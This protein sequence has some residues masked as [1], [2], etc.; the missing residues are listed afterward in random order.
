MFH[1][2]QRSIL[3]LP[4]EVAAQI[5]SS[6]AIPSLTGVVLELLK[7]ALDAKATR[8]DVSVDFARG[9]CTVEDDGLGIPPLEFREEGGLGTL[10][11]TSKYH[12]DEALLGRNGTFLASLAA[13][14]LFTVASRHHEYRTHN[15]ITF[16]QSKVIERQVPAAAHNHVHS[17]HGTRV[18]VRNL[19]GNLP[20]RVKQRALVSEQRGEQDRL[21]DALKGEMARLLL[22][23]QDGVALK[24]RDSDNR[25]VINFS[26]SVSKASG[27]NHLT[28]PRS[29]PLA[30]LLTVLTQANYIAVDDW[31]SW[32][33]ASASTSALSIKGAI[34]L[35]P[36]PSRHVQFISLGIRPLSADA[37]HN[38]LF[39]EVNR[40]FALSS[41]GTIED[42]ADVDEHEKVRRRSDKRYKN[43]G[44]TN[45]QLKSRKHVDKYPM[46]H[47]RISV[48]ETRGASASEDQFF[49]DDANLQNVMHVLGAMVT[50]WLSVHHFRPKQPRKKCHRAGTGSG[51]FGDTAEYG[52]PS[53][54]SQE[55]L[56]APPERRATDR[57]A[58]PRFSSMSTATRKRRR[59]EK[60]I[61]PEPS[62]RLQN[63]AFAQ[64]SRIKSG[65]ADFFNSLS[66]PSKTADRA[67]VVASLN[68]GQDSEV[69]SLQRTSAED[70]A[71]F[72]MQPIG[73]GALSVRIN[74]EDASTSTAQSH[75]D[76]KENDDTILWTDPSTKK[77][78][79]LNAR[80]GCIVP[81]VPPQSITD[82][83]THTLNI[84]QK[85]I[86]K[87][88]RL[89]SRP[90]S[91]VQK[92][93]PWLDHVLQTWDNPIFKPSEKRIQ[94]ITLHEPELDH[95]H[96]HGCSR[97]D[98]D[99][100][101]TEASMSGS[102]RLSKEGLR[103]ARV[104]SQVDKKFILIKMLS[105]SSTPDHEEVLVLIDQHAA[106]ERVQVESLLQDLCTPVQHHEAYQSKLGH[107]S[108]VASI[109][110]EKPAQFSISGQEPI[111]FFTHAPR[112]AAWGVLFDILVSTPTS[113]SSSSSSSTALASIRDQHIL[114]VTALPPA[115]SSRCTADP[116]ILISFLRSAVWTYVQHK[117]LPLPC[118]T[119]TSCPSPSSSADG[120]SV[121]WVRHLATC[122][123]G[124]GDLVNSRACRSAI[125]FN[126]V[127]DRKACEVLVARL[128]K[129]VFPFMCAHGRPSMVPLVHLRGGLAGVPE[130]VEMKEEEAGFVQAWKRWK[131]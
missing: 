130:E 16:H 112:F 53:S 92:K 4:D 14:S 40:L 118:A 69:E 81:D 51:T 117:P 2:S 38:E 6:T 79:L 70:F 119:P 109:V 24:V 3:P 26:T 113:T 96:R 60:T 30:S 102:S 95:T 111:H 100:A 106:D 17:K 28:K 85:S 54:D 101:F 84:T 93:T 13:L 82:S 87:S 47:L 90:S 18:T 76:D 114:S 29:V 10:Y 124:L 121:A 23:W 42:D 41:F 99:K 116:K 33:P 126:D 49:G 98:I 108:P 104:I 21:W 94:Q 45:R 105:S 89:P 131:R 1:K 67:F 20:V 11:C 115:I 56:R 65:R 37:G 120:D 125:M 57:S 35:H 80:T 83:S 44:Y 86:R 74:R 55:I 62:E 127:L 52:N 36:A 50:Q 73:Q 25:V 88:I 39:D 71:S 19:F 103:N 7:N 61:T 63:R 107:T 12:A 78:Y 59:S 128:A 8:I 48:K 110:L 97:I 123:P 27:H 32:V 122:P 77:T 75:T 129:C 58:A 31:A 72:N 43:D 34:S 64:W 5:K 68:S 22:S 9:G 15:S 46:F 66:N 91:D